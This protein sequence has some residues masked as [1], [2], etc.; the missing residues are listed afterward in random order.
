MKKGMGAEAMSILALGDHLS[1]QR[2][3]V[4]S[5]GAEKVL[6]GE[7]PG[8]DQALAKRWARIITQVAREGGYGMLVSPSSTRAKD[9]VPS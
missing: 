4:V 3:I 9:V 5:L 2:D 8:L 7:A 6:M 1:N